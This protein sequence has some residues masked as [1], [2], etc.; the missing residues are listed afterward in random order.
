MDKTKGELTYWE[1]F[2]SVFY[3][4]W[5]WVTCFSA[6]GQWMVDCMRNCFHFVVSLGHSKDLESRL[7]QTSDT[8]CQLLEIGNAQPNCQTNSI[9]W[10]GRETTYPPLSNKPR[11]KGKLC[12]VQQIRELNQ[13]RRRRLQKRQLKSEFTPLQTLSHLFHLVYFVKC[14]QM[15]L[16]LNSKQ[17]YQ[18]SEREKKVV[19]L[20]SRPRQNVNSGTFT[21]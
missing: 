19:V 18:S 10:N 3:S 15:F 12:H 13:Q 6:V 20:C 1:E 5:P 7:R 4:K 21:L 2:Q 8:R 11:V 14:W 17:L 9:L 16:E